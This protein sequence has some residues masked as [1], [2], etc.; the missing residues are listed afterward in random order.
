MTTTDDRN[1]QWQ[2]RQGCSKGIKGWREITA[3]MAVMLATAATVAVMVVTAGRGEKAGG[4]EKAGRTEMLGSAEAAGRAAMAVRR[5]RQ[6]TATGNG[7]G[8]YVKYCDGRE[9]SNSR[10]VLIE[11]RR[12]RS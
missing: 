8:D 2:Q 9:G 5:Q 1:G 7:S 4:E 11:E 10:N 3:A 12:Q 6:A